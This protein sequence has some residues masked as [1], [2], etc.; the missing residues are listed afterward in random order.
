MSFGEKLL[1]CRKRAG[2]SQEELGKRLLVSRQTVSQWETDQTLPTVDNLLRLRELFGIS[3]DELLGVAQTD[4]K[5]PPA[6]EGERVVFRHSPET[7]ELLKKNSRS[8]ILR[9]G[10]VMLVLGFLAGAFFGAAAA[11]EGSRL[12]TAL[13]AGLAIAAVEFLI[14][15]REWRRVPAEL[16]RLAERS[17]CYRLLGDRL[18]VDVSRDGALVST[19]LLRPESTQSC[20]LR[21]ELYL[22]AQDG[23]TYALDRRLLD[24]APALRARFA[25]AG[26]S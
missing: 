13:A 18:Y 10:G 25:R 8:R 15:F 22:L 14:L 21:G 5:V 11:A 16:E 24:A 9:R 2:L 19:V 7:L 26:T 4:Q 3:A 23:L 6:P 1:E 20:T 17:Y 12:F